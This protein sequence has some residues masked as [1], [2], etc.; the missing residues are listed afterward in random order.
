MAGNTNTSTDQLKEELRGVV[1]ALGQR[2]MSGA[3]SRMSGLT[4]RLTESATDGGPVGKAAA[5][6]AEAAMQGDNP[7]TG[8]MKGGLS[9]LVDKAKDKLTGGGGGGAKATKATVIIEQ[10][11]VGVPV[12]V[13]YNQ[14]TQYEDWP[15]FMKKVEV[16]EQDE[17]EPTTKHKAQ[18]FWSHRSWESTIQDQVPDE[19]IVWRSQGEKGHVDGTVTFHE[20]APRLTRILVVLEYYPQGLFERTGNLWRAQGRRARLELKHFR[21]HVMMNTALDPEAVDGWRGEIH[22]EEIKRTHD[23]VVAAESDEES[24][25]SEDSPGADEADDQF[26]EGEESDEASEEDD[27][28]DEGES[29][30]SEPEDDDEAEDEYEADEEEPEEEADEEPADEYD[31]E[32][33]DE[34]E[35]EPADDEEQ[36]EEDERART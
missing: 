20:L 21:R 28:G 26:D 6:G 35:E 2:A 12:S 7:V 31:E 19:R 14:W 33:V 9:G 36:V 27:R 4:G 22:D 23:E 16:A 10:I 11:D 25:E 17:D 3:T 30:E 29:D 32:P 15:S 1:S 5:K 18:V 8:A 13:A 34:D 24:E